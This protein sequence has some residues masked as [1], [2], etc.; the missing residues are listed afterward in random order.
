MA[1]VRI[2]VVAFLSIGILTAVVAA[3]GADRIYSALDLGTLPGGALTLASAINNRAQVVGVSFISG[4]SHA[5]LWEGGTM[6]D[7]G[8]PPGRRHA[9][10]ADINNHGQIVGSTS[11]EFAH[12]VMWDRGSLV[13]LG[14]VPDGFSCAAHAI[15]DRAQVVGACDVTGTAGGAFLW[16]DGVM[17][18]L[19]TLPGGNFT[20]PTDIND[21]GQ[22][23][24]AANTA[25]GDTTR[26]CGKEERW[27]T[28]AHCRVAHP[29]PQV[30]STI[31]A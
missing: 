3:S 7:L 23:V 18:P 26:S 30:A 27:S 31:G 28:S 11:A 17:T 29:A 10:A 21:D 1:R 16:E 15:N 22:I 5:F 2:N 25:S 12:A 14:T 20:F 24:G 6:T 19:G 4:N 13:D 9:G 8:I